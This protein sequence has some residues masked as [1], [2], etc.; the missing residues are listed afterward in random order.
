[1]QA[2]LAFGASMV[3]PSARGCEAFASTLRVSH[4]WTRA[5]VHGV[6]SAVLCMKFDEVTLAD[7]LILVQ[8][9]VAE[10]ARM[11]GPDAGERE[12]VD[13]SIPA[14]RE[15]YLDESSTHVMLVGLKFPLEIGR[16]YPLTLGFEKGGTVFA[17]LSVD[18]T[19][20]R[21]T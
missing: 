20:F 19:P 3:L 7:R 9:P 13:F 16:S 1:M 4:P 15:T 6:T 8:T 18:Y 10:G 21:F 17:S 12:G 2:G 11:A 14:E 5:T